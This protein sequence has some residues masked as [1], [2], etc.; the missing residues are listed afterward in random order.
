MSDNK[1]LPN[2]WV[3]LKTPEVSL[4]QHYRVLGGFSGS[5]IQSTVWRVNSGITGVTL[6]GNHYHFKGHTGSEYV[7]NVCN[8]GPKAA[9][10]PTLKSMK[11]LG[12]L[13]MDSRTDWINMDWIISD[14]T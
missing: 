6:I 13:L 14:D 10:I 1:Y 7:C 9:I 3:V 2:C 4:D 5:Y 11:S 8:Y 12:W